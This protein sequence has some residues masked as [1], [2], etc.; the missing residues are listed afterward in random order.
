MQSPCLKLRLPLPHEAPMNKALRVLLLGIGLAGCGDAG[1]AVSVSDVQV[2]AA[3]PGRDASVAYLTLHN[4]RNQAVVLSSISSPQFARV[5]LHETALH[6]GIASMRRLTSLTLEANTS[7]RLIPGGK[8]LMLFEPG[9]AM[10]PG[11]A[12]TLQFH[13]N[14]DD[15]VVVD[16]PLRPRLSDK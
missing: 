12:I 16:T 8:H 13:F 3:M 9:Q 15:L 1:P 10:P 2:V 14:S 4:H 7:T 5:E 6:K 11:Q